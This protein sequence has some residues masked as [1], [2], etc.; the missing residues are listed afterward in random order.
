M[1]QGLAVLPA[2]VAAPA[3]QRASR[4]LVVQAASP[5]P[6]ATEVPRAEAHN[7]LAALLQPAAR[8]LAEAAA[9]LPPAVPPPGG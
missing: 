3:V 2:P 9:W 6:A 5:G 8:Q 1:R 4:K 7:P